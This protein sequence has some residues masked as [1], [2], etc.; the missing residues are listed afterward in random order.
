MRKLL[1]FVGALALAV[2]ASGAAAG[3]TAGGMAS[4]NVEWV[5][6]VPFEQSSTTGVNTFGKYMVV[7]SWKNF[8]IYDISDPE[9][10]SLLSTRPF[11][12]KFENEDVQTNGE[13]M[14]FSE[15]TPRNILHIWNIEDKSNPVQIGEIANG[16]GH[17]SECILNCKFSYASTGAIVDL[18]KPDKAKLLKQNWKELLGL[19][20]G[21]HDS[22][23]FKPG[24]IIVS[25]YATPAPIVDVRNPLKPKVVGQVPHPQPE[26][27]IFHSGDWP[28]KGKDRFVLMQGEQNATTR[29]SEAD[30]PFMSFDTK[31]WPKKFAFNHVDT[32]RVE[33]GTYADG[34]PAVNGLGCSAHWFEVHPTFKNG[35]LTAVGYY[36]HGTRFIDVAS[37]GKLKEVGYFMPWGG[38]TSAAYWVD[39]KIVYAADYGRGIDILRWTGK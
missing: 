22:D 18:R 35:G 19:S 17:T 14:L 1:A 25:T 10:P 28:N 11:G 9:S 38:S 27:F 24:F 34:S 20:D 12:F 36:E 29:C 15:Q 2:S 5:G 16:G 4:D 3:P 13:I 39:K 7:T 30:G 31:G 6:F 8:S 37:N 33:N 32:F 21:V 26:D 23:E